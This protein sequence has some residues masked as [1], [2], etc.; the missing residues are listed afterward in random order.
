MVRANAQ[1]VCDAGILSILLQETG[2]ALAGM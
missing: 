1:G 2:V